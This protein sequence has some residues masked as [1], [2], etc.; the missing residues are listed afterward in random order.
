[1]QTFPC[2][3]VCFG[4]AKPLIFV[5]LEIRRIQCSQN[6]SV[7][8]VQLFWITSKTDINCIWAKCLSDQLLQSS[9]QRAQ[10]SGKFFT[11]V[12]HVCVC[13]LCTGHCPCKRKERF[14]PWAWS[15]ADCWLTP[16]GSVLVA[17]LGFESRWNTVWIPTLPLNRRMRDMQLVLGLQFPHCKKEWFLCRMMWGFRETTLRTSAF[18]VLHP[19]TWHQVSTPSWYPD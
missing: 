10:V 2:G 9:Q 4:L 16:P 19:S 12:P 1:M 18:Y 3:L 5:Q 8:R 14:M 17:E 15:G 6:L 7:S 13:M 11:C